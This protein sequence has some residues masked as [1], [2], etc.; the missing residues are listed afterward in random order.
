MKK[1]INSLLNGMGYEIKKSNGL[2]TKDGIPVD[3]TEAAFAEFYKRCVPYTF[4]SVEALY[5]LYTSVRYVVKNQIP[6]DFVECGVW[7]G[8]SA[9]MMALALKELGDTSRELYLYDTYEG[10]SEPT[11]KDKDF[12]GSSAGNL[13]K[14]SKKEEEQNVWCFSPIEDVKANLASTGYPAGKIHFIQGKVEETIPGKIPSAVSLLRLDTDWY[15]STYHELK[16]LYPL[17]SRTG[18]LI[19]DDYGHWK[20]AREAADTYFRE[21]GIDLLLHRVNYTVRTALK[22]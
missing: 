6:G 17:L 15:E 7:R 12:R 11:E 22:L 13:M 2:L 4:T 10:M 5:S 21:T 8:G 19:L 9:M 16:Y 1:L 18:V 3:M 14:N 20:G